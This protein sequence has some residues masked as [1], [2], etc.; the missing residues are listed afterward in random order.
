MVLLYLLAS[1]VI[2]LGGVLAVIE[3]G[4]SVWLSFIAPKFG[5]DWTEVVVD[6]GERLYSNDLR[7]I[8]GN[9][10]AGLGV[11]LVGSTLFWLKELVSK[12]FEVEAFPEAR[13]PA[14]L[15][16]SRQI[17][18]EAMLIVAY[19]LLQL[20]AVYL[21]LQGHWLA[22]IGGLV[23]SKFYLALAMG[24]D[25]SMPTMNRHSYGLSA[26]AFLLFK[27]R[28]LSLLALGALFAAP[29]SIGQVLLLRTLQVE[30]AVLAIAL[31]EVLGM[32]GAILACTALS[33]G[34]LDELTPAQRGVP[35][36][37][38]WALLTIFTCAAGASL[39]F[40]AWWGRGLHSIVL[41]KNA[42]WSIDGQHFA[43]EKHSERV[44]EG[45][46]VAK[47]RIVLPI[48]IELAGDITLPPRSV[49]L[50]YRDN[51]NGV[52]GE[53]F[54]DVAHLYGTSQEHGLSLEM[55]I[56]ESDAPQHSREPSGG[57]ELRIRLQPPLSR[58]IFIP[59]F[60]V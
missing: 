27:H 24:L 1:A 44:V 20:G 18:D 54:L 37:W 57:H 23:L 12:N 9:V 8:I 2:M 14:E 60:G 55:T 3:I 29:A 31:L 45:K 33:R 6:I 10:G 36:W 30:Y 42:R 39:V 32:A 34:L 53:V 22:S 19:L 16:L 38:R 47:L 50:E 52:S 43:M 35:G 49:A 51:A 21:G 58:P 5:A 11:V 17:L 40:V 15:S 56:T 46:R 48:A 25:H 7:P 41:L 26:G 4:P 13:S 59:L 28:G